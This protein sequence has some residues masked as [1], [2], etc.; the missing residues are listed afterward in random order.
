MKVNNDDTQN[1]WDALHK[2]GVAEKHA[3]KEDE[4]NWVNEIVDVGAT[5]FKDINFGK[6]YEEA[7]EIAEAIDIEFEKPK[8]HSDT[9][10]ANHGSKVLKSF[11]NDL[12][13]IIERYKEIKNENIS[14]NV[15]KKT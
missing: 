6:A 3:R 8:F 15:Q 1:D 12:P 10:F 13:V 5:C 2:S 7:L 14:S 4:C 9:R 11:L